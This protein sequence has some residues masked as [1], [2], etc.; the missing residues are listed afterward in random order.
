M[1]EFLRR[2][3]SKKQAFIICLTACSFF[4]FPII[5]SN[6]YYIDDMSRAQTNY[7]G[8]AGLGRPMSDYI[9]ILFSLSTNHSVDISPLPQIISVILNATSVFLILNK[10]LKTRT[11]SNILLCSIPLACPLYIQ[12][13]IYK[14]D[15]LSMASAVTMA[16][17]AWYYLNDKFTRIIIS[18]ILLC[19][20]M[21]L[22]QAAVPIY[23]I[24]VL[25][26]IL[27]ACI[28]NKVPFRYT[29]SSICS[30]VL[31]W[32]MYQFI[33]FSFLKS[34]RG[35][36]IFSENNW[37][38]IFSKNFLSFWTLYKEVYGGVFFN[39]LILIMSIGGVVICVTVLLR[40]N[41]GTYADKAVSNLSFLIPF[42]S[43]FVSIAFIA[44][45]KDAIIFPRVAL[46][47]GFSIMLCIYA[48]TVYDK[49]DIS[50]FII[51]AIL[52]FMSIVIAF[53]I[54][55]AC[56]NQ[57][58]LDKSRALEIKSIIDAN[59]LYNQNNT[60]TIGVTSESVLASRVA[61][62]YPLT[63]RINARMNDWAAS[64]QLKY[65]GLRNVSFTFDRSKTMHEADKA[66]NQ[67][68]SLYKGNDFSIYNF[69]N[70]NYVLLGDAWKKCI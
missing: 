2:E 23:F 7:L 52:M 15:S 1:L 21:A 27:T 47:F 3:Y 5:Y 48:M 8:W 40:K 11:I 44:I 33:L 31:G 50:K 4:M 65:F 38:E 17:L 22:Y 45:L 14:Y 32:G 51:S 37:T 36:L 41:N 30:S 62:I 56:R 69:D 12:N 18:G 43:F 35:E 13:M 9:F 16:I 55:S 6:I 20:S 19:M 42:L 64:L 24:M 39:L 34:D 66:C 60:T 67:G 46:G 63:K 10:G 61:E 53:A 70:K 26:S 29:I 54:M 25:M 58:E 59:P 68:I 28:Y 57:Y 49:T